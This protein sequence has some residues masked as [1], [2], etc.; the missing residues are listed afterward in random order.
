[1]R[2]LRRDPDGS[3]AFSPDVRELQGYL[4]DES[5]SGIEA[6]PGKGTHVP[7]YILGSSLLGARLAAQYGLRHAFASH[8]AP[9][10]LER[11]MTLYRAEFRPRPNARRPS[12]SPR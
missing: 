4:A 11:A 7:L 5:P 12:P 6:I 8:F 2:A 1:M 9:D 3:G 10:E